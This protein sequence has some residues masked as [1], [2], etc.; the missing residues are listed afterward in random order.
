VKSSTIEAAA[1]GAG[2]LAAVAAGIHPD[3]PQAAQAMTRR[4]A[5][6]VKPDARRHERYSRLYEDVYRHLFPALQPYLRQLAEH[7]Q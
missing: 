3:V 6:P 2:I 5:D 1:L 4:E 7:V